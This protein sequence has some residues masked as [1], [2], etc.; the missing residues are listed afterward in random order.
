MYEHRTE[1]LLTRAAFRV[2]IAKHVLSAFGGI[3]VALGIGV[4][5]YHILNH[6]PWD[7]ALVDASMI[8]GGMGPVNPL[9]GTAAKLFASAYAL[10]SGLFFIGLMGFLL[11]PFAHRL[12][13]H[14]HVD[15]D[16]G[17]PSRKR[18]SS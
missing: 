10:F 2:R 16:A 6:L 11:A 12:M 17:K 14:F 18:S 8:L 3:A 9:Q 7:D 5:G 13:H 15:E 1:K 4:L